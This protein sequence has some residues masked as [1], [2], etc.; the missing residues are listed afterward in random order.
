MAKDIVNDPD[1]NKFRRKLLNKEISSK[2]RRVNELELAINELNERIKNKLT[3]AKHGSIKFTMCM[4]EQSKLQFLD[5]V[6]ISD[7]TTITRIGLYITN[8]PILGYI[9]YMTA[10]YLLNIN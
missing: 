7:Q 10:M 4:A 3:E 1:I 2:R 9:R 8:Q 6:I 5:M